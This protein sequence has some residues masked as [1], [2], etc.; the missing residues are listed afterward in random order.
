MKIV[1]VLAL[2]A[3]S[4]CLAQTSVPTTAF[5]PS[6]ELNK[7]LPTWLRFSGEYRSRAEGF[8]GG[9][10]KANSQDLYLLSRLRLNMQIRTSK[11]FRIFAQAQDA[12]IFWND[13]VPA[14]APYQRTMNLRLAY[15]DLGN[16]EGPLTL[17]VGRQELDFGDQRL[18]GTANWLNVPHNFDAVRA[19][20]HAHGYR[21]DAFSSFIVVPGDGTLDHH[22][23]G[24]NLHGLY[25][26]L[27]KLIPD[28]VVE[29][30]VFWR[31]APR[32]KNE[33]GQLG[34]LDT[35]SGGVR[36]VGKLPAAHVDYGTEVAIQRGNI[37]ADPVSAWAGHWVAGYT[38]ASAYQPRAFAEYNY[39]S[40]DQN[41][42]DGHI[43]TF[44]QLYPTG[45]DKFGLADQVGWRNIRDVH[46]G[47]EAKPRR[48][49]KAALGVHSF[50]LASASDGLYNAAGAMIARVSNG[51]AGTHV[52]D[53]LDAQGIWAI[54]G[55][56]QF[57]AG[58]GHIFPGQ[59]LKRATRGNPYTYPYFMC[60]YSF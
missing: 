30:Y 33:D 41:P 54:N 27:E 18:V 3:A 51:S 9:G 19:T 34:S 58:I 36:W 44:D 57:G 40:G 47:V 23:E 49:V 8:D 32:Q 46:G 5:V 29:P 22:L 48:A 16:P 43:G 60:A 35:K 31:L 7:E 42:H 12:R 38:F 53:E 59:F 15:V 45:H 2:C 55:Q 26:G 28:A 10:F 11:W 52:G 56:L 20:F 14:A 1:A 50:W 21:V 6:D 37:G 17:R 25:G 24:N 39:A 13:R 4:L